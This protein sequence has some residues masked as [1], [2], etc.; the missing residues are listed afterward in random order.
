MFPLY[1][2]FHLKRLPALS[3]YGNRFAHLQRPQA[4]MG[5][6]SSASSSSAAGIL[7]IRRESGVC[8]SYNSAVP[9]A[10]VKHTERDTSS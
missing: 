8:I 2:V 10:R 4:V 6:H 7:T 3:S 1:I 9:N 5:K